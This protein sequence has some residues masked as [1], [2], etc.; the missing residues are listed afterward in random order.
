LFH[1]KRREVQ[2]KSRLNILSD[3][4]QKK[5]DPLQPEILSNSKHAHFLSNRT[6]P[7]IE[8]EEGAF[9]VSDGDGTGPVGEVQGGI[10]VHVAQT[11]QKQSAIRIRRIEQMY[12]FII[13]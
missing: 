2:R 6:S 11:T 8:G 10:L 4:R 5:L 13:L 1:E 9:P 12:G 7:E 3:V